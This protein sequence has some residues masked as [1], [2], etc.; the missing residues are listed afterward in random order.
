MK[1]GYIRVSTQ[2]QN[3]IRQEELMTALG[4]DQIYIDRMSGK[5]TNRP[6]LQSMLEFV[7]QG[8]TVVVESNYDVDM[9]LGGDYPQ[10]LKDRIT[11]GIGHL[12]NDACAE[13]IGKFLHPGLR[14]LFLCHLSGNNN[15]P[16]LAYD[17]ARA[18]LAAAGVE[19]GTISLRV[20]KRG[21]ASPLLVL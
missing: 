14:N 5:N 2:E 3:T 20:L 12:S 19:P 18:A 9:L 10:Y 11:H 16:E 17:S 21:I 6:E 13:A 7:R 15:T 1:I 4:A 8:D